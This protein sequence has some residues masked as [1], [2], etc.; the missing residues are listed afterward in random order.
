MTVAPSPSAHSRLG[1]CAWQR[2][3]PGPRLA[4]F[5]DNFQ[6]MRMHA[7][8]ELPRVLPGSGALLCIPLGGELFLQNL[9]AQRRERL[10]RAFVICNRHAVLD[11]VCDAPVELLIATFR[12]GR[13]RYLVPA[14]FAELQDRFTAADELWGAGELARLCEQLAASP[15]ADLRIAR[16]EGFLERHLGTRADARLDVLQDCLYLAPDTRISR[17]AAEGGWSLRHFERL[18]TQAYGVTPKFFARVARL[19]QVARNM[20]LGLAPNVAGAVMDAGFYDQ[21][22]FIHELHRLAGLSP[23]DFSRGLRERPHFYNP[24]ALPRYR[25]QLRHTLADSELSRINLRLARPGAAPR[26]GRA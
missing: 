6:I 9:H 22:H 2:F 10:A 16:L 8:G 4:L 3:A 21:P 18:F 13:L 14:S 25:Q 23:A 12:P 24:A 5:A 20:A 17:L 26:A 7:A 15:D 11:L 1:A 19:Q